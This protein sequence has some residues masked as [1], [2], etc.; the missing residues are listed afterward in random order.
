MTRYILAAAAAVAGLAAVVVF[1]RTPEGGVPL[2]AITQIATHP[3]LDEVRAGIVAGL[4][5][6]GYVDGRDVEILFRNANG[7]ASLTLPIAQ[8]FVR[9]GAAVIVPISTPSTLAVAKATDAI[10]IIFSGVADPRGSGLV[11]DFNRPGGNI[12]GVCDQW[13][14]EDQVRAFLKYFPRTA[15]IGLLYTRGD[16]VSKLGV[17]ALTE[18]APKLGFKLRLAPVSAAED[19]YPVAVSLLPRVDAVFTGIDHLILENMD[20]LTKAAREAKRPLFGGE[21]G[22]VRKGAVLALSID[23][24][25]FGDETA[26]IVVQVLRGADPGAIPVKVLSDGVLMVNRAV[27]SGFGLDLAALGHDGA[28][29]ID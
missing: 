23:M 19:I 17:D 27:A 7:D 15:S 2:V 1:Q 21:P 20:S 22:S 8:D 6:R 18:L 16:D 3:A 10:P 26:D 5:S 9:R 12:T 29:F 13:P 14:F 24:T 11:T 4:E 25:R 28:R